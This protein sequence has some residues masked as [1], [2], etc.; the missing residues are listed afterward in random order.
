MR[1][2]ARIAIRTRPLLEEVPTNC[3]LGRVVDVPAA[4][5]LRTSTYMWKT[6]ERGQLTRDISI[7]NYR[8]W[9]G[10]I[11]PG[12]V[13]GVDQGGEEKTKEKRKRGK[14]KHK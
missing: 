7:T 3:D 1:E 13:L 12:P 6:K 10:K 8:V 9:L 4:R 5:S 2:V 14:K 11:Q